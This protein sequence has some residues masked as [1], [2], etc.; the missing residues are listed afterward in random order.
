MKLNCQ[1]KHWG[2]FSLK[3]MKRVGLQWLD[4]KIRNP[5]N[6]GSEVLYKDLKMKLAENPTIAQ[7]SNI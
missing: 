7:I 1:D 2:T 3:T 4:M 6:K 5:E